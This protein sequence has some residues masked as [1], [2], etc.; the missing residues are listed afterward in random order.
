MSRSSW[1]SMGSA[2]AAGA[3]PWADRAASPGRGG[4]HPE[5]SPRERLSLRIIRVFAEPW[6]AL[7][8][9]DP[10]RVELF[11]ERLEAELAGKPWRGRR[12]IA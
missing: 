3:R 9:A 2:L 1:G 6:P 7:A 8:R 5:P 12:K 4:D 11:E 10:D